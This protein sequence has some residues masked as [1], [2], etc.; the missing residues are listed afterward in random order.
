MRILHLDLNMREI[1]VIF[2]LIF[3]LMFG[4]F[5]S[6]NAENPP[7]QISIAIL[8]AK[9]AVDQN[10]DSLRL[11]LIEQLVTVGEY[12]EA[13]VHLKHIQNKNIK[14][15]LKYKHHYLSTL[16]G[17]YID[18]QT[19]NEDQSLYKQRMVS[20]LSNTDYKKS[21]HDFCF[22][23]QSIALGLERPDLALKPLEQLAHYVPSK[24]SY[25][26]EQAG[27]WA[28][29][30][31]NNEKAK[32]LY[33]QALNK[34][35]SA[36]TDE[37][38]QT[39][40]T[41]LDKLNLHELSKKEMPIFC[42]RQITSHQQKSVLLE[43]CL[44]HYADQQDFKH[45]KEIETLLPKEE[46]NLRLFEKLL[47]LYLGKTLLEEAKNTSKTILVLA[48]NQLE[49][50][51]QL[52][53]IH[54]WLGEPQDALILWNQ[55]YQQTLLKEDLNAIKRLSEGLY[56]FD[57]IE[58]SLLT[59]LEQHPND[60]DTLEHLSR[61]KAQQ[62]YPNQALKYLTRLET[63]S[64]SRVD[65]YEKKIQLLNES[66]QYQEAVIIGEQGLNEYPNNKTLRQQVAHSYYQLEDFGQAYKHLHRL[67]K[68]L[69]STQS[70]ETYTLIDLAIYNHEIDAAINTFTAITV[71]K[72][73]LP[74]KQTQSKEKELYQ[75]FF[76]RKLRPKQY[77]LLSNSLIKRWRIYRDPTTMRMALDNAYF[78]PNDT[79]HKIIEAA[80]RTEKRWL[81]N[82]NYLDLSYQYYSDK[83][84]KKKALYYMGLLHKQKK[85]DPIIFETLIWEHIEQQN[86]L[87]LERLLNSPMKP[88]K[89]RAQTWLAL[90][91]AYS[92]LDLPAQAYDNYLNAYHQLVK[93]DPYHRKNLKWLSYLAYYQDQLGY[94]ANAKHL[95]ASIHDRYETLYHQSPKHL[96]IEDK[97]WLIA[98]RKEFSDVDHSL[99]LLTLHQ[100]DTS[101][102]QKKKN[103][104]RMMSFYEWYKHSQQP[105][106]ALFWLEQDNTYLN[107]PTHQKEKALLALSTHSL[108]ELSNFLHALDT[109]KSQGEYLQGELEMGHWQIAE[110]IA[111]AKLNQ[112]NTHSDVYHQ[113]HD[114][115]WK[116][117]E[118]NHQWIK[119][120]TK[121]TTIN[122][123]DIQSQSL[124]YRDFRRNNDNRYFYQISSGFHSLN[125]DHAF[126][127]SMAAN[128]EY[129]ASIEVTTD[130]YR[131]CKP[132]MHMTLRSYQDGQQK[133]YLLSPKAKIHCQLSPNSPYAYQTGL[134]IN[135][136]TTDSELLRL[137]GNKDR[138]YIGISRFNQRSLSYQ[139]Q[140]S[141][142]TYET[143]QSTLARGTTIDAHFNY[144]IF[145]GYEYLD[146]T[147]QSQYAN[148]SF[149][150][151]TTTFNHRHLGSLTYS[152]DL[153]ISEKNRRAGIGF[154]YGMGNPN[155]TTTPYSHARF[156]I[157]GELQQDFSRSET[158]L[159]F[160]GFIGRPLFGRDE[161]RLSGDINTNHLGQKSH[162]FKL[163]YLKSF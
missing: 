120:E 74:S 22:L 88:R 84:D 163:S 25:W 141:L 122:Q 139:L 15:T 89:Y 33:Q 1:Y 75:Q 71:D 115:L 39:L 78:A 73:S 111:T 59:H 126:H 85:Q 105:E 138:Y 48:P 156:Q 100:H 116:I 162:T 95:R 9:L 32:Q 93:G 103:P 131:Q 57:I 90:A 66:E 53:Q 5:P 34:K 76:K 70:P 98:L 8:K 20:I 30:V 112:I 124:T 43:A 24:S 18:K 144:P 148:R 69:L 83:K 147:L 119:A 6:A 130:R 10:N 45:L 29:A 63:L 150:N 56:E 4:Y 149:E 12:T 14:S 160:S 52:A 80:Q 123:L 21:S 101:S 106:Q 27:D 143:T 3:C 113:L 79:Q 23:S 44:F 155:I 19:N 16:W 142:E 28:T 67:K 104:E 114:S 47:S 26:L 11:S 110:E 97:N 40:Q 50:Q 7:S 129:F 132:H 17:L 86:T 117:K 118:Q 154:L 61:L 64:H 137:F 161:I 35:D 92:Y 157:A 159:N 77:A 99:N 152:S 58:R 140:L 54:E 108:S 36:L 82:S 37:K 134:D 62:G 31:D 107:T 94:H 41:K 55:V 91:A 127:H 60:Q 102:H 46:N 65:I 128:R 136:V 13:L 133:D 151:D 49:S 68:H 42:K 125:S 72:T 38:Y 2:T 158:S 135:T 145:S 153:F 146:I 96:S 51:R 81:K 121:T 87:E 109:P